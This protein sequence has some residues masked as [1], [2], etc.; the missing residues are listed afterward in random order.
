MEVQDP[1]CGMRIDA[2][3]A[4][5]SVEHGGTTY[6]FCGEGCK[7][8]FEDDPKRY[9]EGAAEGEGSDAG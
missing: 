2:D 8:A 5:A 9:L 4:A 6:Y 7:R 1:V 3:A